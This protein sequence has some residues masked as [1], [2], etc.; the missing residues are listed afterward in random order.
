MLGL[1]AGGVGAVGGILGSIFGSRSARRNR[2]RALNVLSEEEDRLDN[3]FNQEYYQNYLNR[4]DVQNMLSTLRTYNNQQSSMLKNNAVVSGSTPEAIAAQQK[5][6]ADV[7][8]QSV[9]GIAANADNWK[10]GIL[11]SYN[12]GKSQLAG[13]RYNTYMSAAQ[14]GN[15]QQ[16]YGQNLFQRGLENIADYNF[17]SNSKTG[18]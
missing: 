16:M 13:M 2:N 1:I 5:Q 14:Q 10:S 17:L 8:G 6:L 18:R 9:S 3:L 11:Q 7:Y 4:S 15:A 12:A